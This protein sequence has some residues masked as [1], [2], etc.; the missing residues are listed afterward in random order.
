MKLACE[1]YKR[2]YQQSLDLIKNWLIETKECDK[3]LE[4]I[5]HSQN[6]MKLVEDSLLED[7]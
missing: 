6:L 7:S 1:D 4:L 3:L 2:G 5:N